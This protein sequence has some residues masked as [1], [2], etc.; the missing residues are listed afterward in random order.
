MDQHR[1]DRGDDR[2]V[3]PVSP[4]TVAGWMG[5]FFEMVVQVMTGQSPS[6]AE[7]EM[8]ERRE[9]RAAPR[10]SR[11]EAV[12]ETITPQR[13]MLGYLNTGL[14]KIERMRQQTRMAKQYRG[15][16]ETITLTRR[17]IRRTPRRSRYLF[18]GY[19]LLLKDANQ[20]VK[21]LYTQIRHTQ[22]H[23]SSYDPFALADE[24]RRLE[25]SLRS[26]RSPAQQAEIELRL[27]SRR[28]LLE[29]VQRLD[30]QLDTLLA[31]LGSIASALELN[32]L[33]V[34]KIAGEA[35]Y[36]S[37]AGMLES[38]MQDVSEQL[39]LLEQSLRELNGR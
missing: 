3:P 6:H 15:A 7:P 39:E 27:E 4:A 17:A 30:E 19:G 11:Q 33:R 37:G 36:Q 18:K 1:S 13:P 32:H 16:M 22:R 14:Y 38:R 25:S 29:S 2:F 34:V 21:E 24:I 8:V 20:R 23:L 31:Q 35:S 9:D 5:K 10:Q 26:S 28:D 12:I